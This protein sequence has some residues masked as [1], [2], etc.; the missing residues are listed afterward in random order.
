MIASTA[1]T[2][3][4]FYQT[5]NELKDTIKRLNYTLYLTEHCVNSTYLHF[6]QSDYH[7]LISNYQ[8]LHSHLGYYSRVLQNSSFNCDALSICEI[9]CTPPN[10]PILL[11]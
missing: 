11:E 8:A 9:N 3:Q 4:D 1:E 10:N 6:H 7:A 5:A 2:Y